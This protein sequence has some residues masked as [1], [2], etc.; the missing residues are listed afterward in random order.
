MNDILHTT[1]LTHTTLA[2]FEYLTN[3]STE[4][5]KELQK[6]H[7]QNYYIFT[8]KTHIYDLLLFAGSVRG[9]Y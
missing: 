9:H 6:A 2:F 5:T 7:A 1:L 3:F 4:I 8:E